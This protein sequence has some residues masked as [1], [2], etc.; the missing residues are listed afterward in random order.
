ME[1]SEQKEE[2]KTNQGTEEAAAGKEIPPW[3]L[4]AEA[5]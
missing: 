2:M 1:S 3:Y 4:S 5:A